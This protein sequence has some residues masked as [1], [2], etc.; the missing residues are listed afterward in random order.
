MVSRP[1]LS[2]IVP[3]LNEAD[4]VERLIAHL[5]RQELETELILID[6]GSSDETVALARRSGA[7]VAVAARGRGSQMNQG[8]QLASAEMLCFLH[9]DSLFECD[10]Q[11]AQS[12]TLFSQQAFR[13][14]RL[15]GHFG[16]RFV[17]QPPGNRR[18]FRFMEAKTISHRRGTI[19]GDQGLLLHRQY[20]DWLGG[21]DESMPILEDQRLATKIFDS[22]RWILLPGKLQTS[23]RRFA[24]EGTWQRYALMALIMSLHDNGLA[25]VIDQ[26]PDLYVEQSEARELQV[27][28]FAK[29]ARVRLASALRRDPAL[30]LR[31]G[32]FVQKNLWQLPFWLDVWLG[33]SESAPWTKRF[34]RRVMPRL[35]HP[36]LELLA[37]A[38]GAGLLLAVIPGFERASAL[39]RPASKKTVALD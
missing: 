34:E 35:D 17:D 10:S 30:S 36:L 15:A 18:L 32:R 13:K 21:F 9:A 4:G 26:F 29:A 20:F 3:V 5:Q 24:A 8:A 16:L 6:G 12:L 19:N 37:A 33:N 27:S 14:D 38:G 7:R 28:P 31:V 2:I 39:I 11:L 25:D 1:E 22:G 23:A